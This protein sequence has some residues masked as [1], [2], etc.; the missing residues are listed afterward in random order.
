VFWSGATVTDRSLSTDVGDWTTGGTA[1]SQYRVGFSTGVAACTPP[2]GGNVEGMQVSGETYDDGDYYKP[3]VMSRKYKGELQILD[4]GQTKYAL[5]SG[6]RDQFMD[7]PGFLGNESHSL[8]YSVIDA[9]D[10]AYQYVDGIR[11]TEEKYR[12]ID[13]TIHFCKM[14]EGDVMVD[15]ADSPLY[16]DFTTG[17]SY[18]DQRL[19]SGAPEFNGDYNLL[20]IVF[21]PFADKPM[22][23]K[24]PIVSR[25]YP[26]QTY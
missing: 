1:D 13:K 7:T 4:D 14:Y 9:T 12:E 16:G 10:G 5:P 18:Y 8:S 23:I 26:E 22:F 21:T 11:Y 24:I 6:I 17:D 15:A 20:D 2:G 19:V 3:Y 25:A